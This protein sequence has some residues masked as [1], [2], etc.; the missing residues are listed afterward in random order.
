MTIEA[1]ERL[2]AVQFATTSRL[3]VAINVSNVE[4]SLLFY[5]TLFGQEPTKLQADYAKF[6]VAELP[7][8]FTL[9]QHSALKLGEGALSHFGINTKKLGQDVN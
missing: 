3:H 5:K 7:V 6:E 2:S 4:K 9:N 8:N 1:Q